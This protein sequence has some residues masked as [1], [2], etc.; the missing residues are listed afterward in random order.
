MKTELTQAELLL[1][2]LRQSLEATEPP[3]PED[4]GFQRYLDFQA[5]LQ[6]LTLAHHFQV[7]IDIDPLD[8]AAAANL[9]RSLSL[10]ERSR[11][12]SAKAEKQANSDKARDERSLQP[13]R[14]EARHFLQSE[15]ASGERPAKELVKVARSL[16]ISISTLK[17]AKASLNI[18]STQLAL[19]DKTRFWV[20]SLPEQSTETA[21]PNQENRS[22]GDILESFNLVFNMNRKYLN[23]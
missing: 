13:E 4:P 2:H 10:V 1:I 3:L 16:G 15:L 11:S 18:I 19:P 5:L 14:D 8:K 17:R 6:Q 7:C 20:W 21:S 22:R 23:N 12:R 9:L